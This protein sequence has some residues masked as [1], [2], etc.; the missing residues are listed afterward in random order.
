MVEARGRQDA[1]LGQ[2]SPFR[3]P[4]AARPRMAPSPLKIIWMEGRLPDNELLTSLAPTGIAQ[5]P[6]PCDT[7]TGRIASHKQLRPLRPSQR[8]RLPTPSAAHSAE[9]AKTNERDVQVLSCDLPLHLAHNA[10]D[11][12]SRANDT[13]TL[14][15]AASNE[16][17]AGF[18]ALPWRD[19]VAAL[20][21]LNRVATG[22][23]LSGI[24]LVGAPRA[25]SFIDDPIF[26]PVL[27]R[28]A[29]LRMPLHI[30]PS[31]PRSPVQRAYSAGFPDEVSARLSLFGRGAHNDACVQALRLILSG[32]LDRWPDLTLVSGHWGEMIPFF[33]QRLDDLIP[34]GITGLHRTIT[35]SYRDQV[36]VTPSGMF[37]AGQFSFCRDLLGAERILFS[38]EPAYSSLEARDWLRSLPVR[39]QEKEAIAHR[40]A[41]QLLR[42]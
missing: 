23:S 37:H 5:A 26:R 30:H 39:D 17:F 6:Y 42:L 3:Q 36:Y 38:T 14:A 41:E 16:F 19:P 18:A 13:L 9:E 22:H 7:R 29:E 21:E 33:L 34:P 40:N 28:I 15:V 25:D 4:L 8:Q 20:G 31:A 35:E 27:A 1:D 11:L 10:V 2:R 12:V 32:A 24:M